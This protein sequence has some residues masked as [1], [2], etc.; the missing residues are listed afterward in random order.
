M[1]ERDVEVV[2]VKGEHIKVQFRRQ[3]SC[4]GCANTDH[5]GSG[6]LSKAF[7]QRLD[8]LDMR[9]AQ[10]VAVGDFVRVGI[11]EQSLVRGTLVLYL[12]PLLCLIGAALLASR[13]VEQWQLSELWVLPALIGGGW[14][15]FKWAGL[16]SARLVA[17]PVLVK[18]LSRE[19]QRLGV[20]MIG[21]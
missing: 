11:S 19:Q 7:S 10:P 15:G 6:Q 16:L 21:G 1:I 13:L 18:V 12:L 14:G 9:C 20:E 17:E 2:A 3:S 5:C 8:V 4:D